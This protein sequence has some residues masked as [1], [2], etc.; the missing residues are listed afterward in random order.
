MSGTQRSS[1]GLDERRKKLLFRCWHRGMREMDLLMGQF[2]DARIA[3]LSE[4]D[5]N[6]LELLIEVPDQDLFQWLTGTTS[7]PEN[8]DF[9]VFRA[10]KA[11]HDEREHQL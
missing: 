5:L 3:Q 11:F 7:V 8:Y 4:R 1:A 2:A 10:F 6:D 9:A